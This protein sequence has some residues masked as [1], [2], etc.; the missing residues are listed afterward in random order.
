MLITTLTTVFLSS[1]LMVGFCIQS[2]APDERLEVRE[3][4]L[5]E[6]ILQAENRQKTDRS[7]ASPPADVVSHG[8]GIVKFPSIPGSGTFSAT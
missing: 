2:A 8:M 6:S 4:A 5:H 7:T 3:M 1:L